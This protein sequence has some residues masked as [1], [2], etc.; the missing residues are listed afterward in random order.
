MTTC[1]MVLTW[2]EKLQQIWSHKKQKA[3]LLE[4][5]PDTVLEKVEQLLNT[6]LPA[7]IIIYQFQIYQFQISMYIK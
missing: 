5:G 6:E 1:N 3:S 4:R 2:R 7:F